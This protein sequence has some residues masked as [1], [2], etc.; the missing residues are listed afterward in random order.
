MRSTYTDK[1]GN[2]YS[3]ICPT[4]RKGTIVTVPRSITHYVATEYG[5]IN[6]KGKSTWER[7]EDLISI[8][9]PKFRDELIC[10]AQELNI[11]TRTNRLI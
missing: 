2:I 11:W 1:Q 6:M 4:L 5:I 10:E 7:A 3:K 8:A 9:H